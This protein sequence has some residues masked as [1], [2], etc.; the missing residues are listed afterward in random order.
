MSLLNSAILLIVCAGTWLLTGYDKA[1]SGESKRGR[2][3]TRAL[4]TIV[5]TLLTAVL[6][7]MLENQPGPTGVPLLLIVPI[8]IALVLRS[9]LSEVFARGI[10]G[11]VDPNLHDHRELDMGVAARHRDEISRLIRNG[12]KSEAIQLCKKL[13]QSGELDES[14]LDMTLAY[15]GVDPKSFG[16]QKLK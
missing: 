12:E 7:G 5:V 13:K 1:A 9:S 11:M 10:M 2:Y 16:R 3:F 4:R 6:L 8:S 15:L 14:T